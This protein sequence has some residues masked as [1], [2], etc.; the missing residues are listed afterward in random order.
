MKLI[1]LLFD[2]FNSP[3][4]QIY[5]Q[6]EKYSGHRNLEDFQAYVQKMLDSKSKSSQKSKQVEEDVPD[7]ASPVLALSTE[8]FESGIEKGI[9]FVKFFAPWYVGIVFWTACCFFLN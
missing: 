4:F 8:T 6:V 1:A 5:F 3:L 9:T 7:K 2:K